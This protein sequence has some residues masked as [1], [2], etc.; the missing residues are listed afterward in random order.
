MSGSEADG[1]CQCGHVRFAIKG[2]PLFRAYCH[3]KTCQA[4]NQ[5]DY[6]DVV[7]MRSGD[8]GLSGAEHIAFEFLQNPPV[9]KRGRCANCDGVAVET[10]NLP[11][12][13]ELTIIP[14]QT[15]D[16]PAGMPDP[17][18]HMYY[19]RR[20]ADADDALPKHSGNLRSQLA[21]ARA[22][23]GGLRRRRGDS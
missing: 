9:V 13:P 6:G 4:Y 23:L 15:L 22:L 8:V 1:G 11:M 7:V 16:H 19:N 3:C 18:F 14:A 10:A 2:R 17:A 5:A 20:V 21:F 12:L